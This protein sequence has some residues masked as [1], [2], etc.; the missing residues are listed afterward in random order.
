M[1]KMLNGC[2]V[3]PKKLLLETHPSG[4]LQV[5]FRVSLVQQQ[6]SL[7]RCLAQLWSVK[8]PGASLARLQRGG[9]C[10]GGLPRSSSSPVTHDL[11]GLCGASAELE[12]FL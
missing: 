11:T 7:C 1:D 2:L 8:N 4:E 6:L 9:R 10:L 12:S 5:R 3:R